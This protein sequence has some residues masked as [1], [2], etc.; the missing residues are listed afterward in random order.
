MGKHPRAA[1]YRVGLPGEGWKPA[2]MKD[3]Q[4]AWAH[5]DAPAGIRVHSECVGH[6]DA[7]LD[8]FLDHLRIGWTAWT[9]ESRAEE[10]LVDRAALRARV[11]ATLDG[12]PFRHEF[13]LVKKDGCLFDLSLSARPDAFEAARPA[14]ERVVAGFRFPV[15]T[16]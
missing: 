13:L 15:E 11:T 2:P 5:R 14:F 16:R 8:E 6:G 4:V 1:S 9:V 10:R 7:G 12:V 3:V